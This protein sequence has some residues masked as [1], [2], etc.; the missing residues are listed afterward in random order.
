MS[1]VLAGRAADIRE[2]I[3]AASLR[4]GRNPSDVR[5]MAVTKT[6][7]RETVLE[8]YKAGIR[9]FGENRVSEAAEKYAD[10]AP[11]AELHLIGHLQTN[12]AKAAAALFPWVDSVDS[13]HTAQALARRLEALG[14]TANILLELN[15]SGEASKSGYGSFEDLERDLDGIL[16]LAPLRLRGLMTVGP[17]TQDEGEI[18]RAFRNLNACMDRL[19]RL[20]PASCRPDTLSMGMSSDFEIAIEEGATLVRLGTVLFGRRDA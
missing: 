13:L 2:R 8:A 11:E 3:R 15:T 10:F 19:L 20:V 14:K 7:P 5:L 12:K 6:H 17:L 4:A 18:R 16:L 1:S 9:V